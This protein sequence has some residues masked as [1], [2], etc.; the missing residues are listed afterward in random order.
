MTGIRFVFLDRDG[1]INQKAPEGQYISEWSKFK[2]L[3]GA[4]EAIARLNQSRRTVIVVTNQ[5]G[6]A[7]GHYSESDLV[8]MHA[9]LQEELARNGARLDAIYYC[10]HDK[11][12][13]ECRKPKPGLFLDAFRDYPDA[14]P[15]NS[16]IIGD[17]LS[18]I[19]AGRGLGMQAYFIRGAM[20]TRK[21]GAEQAEKLANAAFDSLA[22][23][24]AALD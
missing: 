18:D 21:P 2:L 14:S 13:C 5:R 1:V 8:G 4:A 15:E 22:D 9:R 24:V 16:L 3:P 19:E 23:A 11:N 12:A 6:I 10:P 7:L 20:E 17:S